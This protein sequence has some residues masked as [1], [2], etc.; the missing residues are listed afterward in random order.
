MTFDLQG[1]N[2]HELQ[3]DIGTIHFL[4]HPL[5]SREHVLASNLGELYDAYIRHKHMHYSTFY[6][7]KLKA[8]RDAVVAMKANIDGIDKNCKL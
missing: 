8:L 3:V 7:D 6:N 2:E 4:H 1:S 5:M